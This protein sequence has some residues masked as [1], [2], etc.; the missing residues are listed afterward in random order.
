EE[1]RVLV[2]PDLIIRDTLRGRPRSGV[3]VESRD[4]DIDIPI[5]F[6]AATEPGGEQAAVAQCQYR[7]SMVRSPVRR[8]HCGSSPQILD[9]AESTLRRRSRS[10]LWR[11]Q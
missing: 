10:A 3:R 2:R 4:E 7:R 11:W 9:A 6:I 5:A 8:N 1:P